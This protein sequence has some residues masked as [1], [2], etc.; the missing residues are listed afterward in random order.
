MV[1]FFDTACKAKKYNEDNFKHTPFKV[2]QQSSPYIFGGKRFYLSRH[3][4]N[5]GCRNCPNL[6]DDGNVY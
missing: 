1:L 3:V 5:C 2:V 6:Q 4:G